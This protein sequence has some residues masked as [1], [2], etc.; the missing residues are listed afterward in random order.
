MARGRPDREGGDLGVRLDPATGHPSNVNRTRGQ[1]L[2]L[3]PGPPNST[4]VTIDA[5]AG[6]LFAAC[7]GA[8]HV[9]ATR[10]TFFRLNN[11][12]LNWGRG[13]LLWTQYPPVPLPVPPIL[14]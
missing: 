6:T 13:E 9:V 2:G 8:T 4:Q 10:A 14:P 12:A 3:V 1:Y 5:D 7:F 11:I